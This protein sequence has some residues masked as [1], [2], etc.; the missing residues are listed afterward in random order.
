[1]KTIKIIIE[2]S[3]DAYSAYAENAEGINGMGDTAAEA[4]KSA[5]ESI[6]IQKELDNFKHK[7][8]QVVFRYDIQSLLN[9]YKKVFSLAAMERI[10]GIDQKYLQHYSTGLKKPRPERRKKIEK[11]LHDLGAELMALEL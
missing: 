8:Y 11:S 2:K 6:K 10:T 3:K 5:L 7:D 4:R 9:H 1:M